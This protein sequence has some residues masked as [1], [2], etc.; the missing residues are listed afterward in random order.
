[1]RVVPDERLAADDVLRG[2][3][4]GVEATER[5]LQKVLNQNGVE[6]FG[7]KGDVFDPNRHQALFE[8]PTSEV[9]PGTVVDVTKTGYA[10]GDRVL[11]PAE[12][13]VSKAAS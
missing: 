3:H 2:L 5:E 13:G 4:E 1:M 9:D 12:V 11:R 6:K 8:A 10:I 7:E